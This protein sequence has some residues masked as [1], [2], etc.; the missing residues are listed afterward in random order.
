MAT[1]AEAGLYDR[2]AAIC[3]A[4]N[5]ARA[6]EDRDYMTRDIFYDGAPAA[7]I[8]S[9]R[10]KEEIVAIV[11]EAAAAGLA[12]F[13][14][15]GGMSYT[16]G[17]VPSVE[18]SVLIDLSALDQIITI[19]EANMFVTVQP[20]VTWKQLYEALRE[21]G[22]R[23]PAFGT[24]S[25]AK[26]TVGGGLSQGS[27]F[28]GSTQYGT[29]ADH[30]LGLEV[31]LA[32]GSLVRTGQAA[33]TGSK[34][35]FRWH[36]PD[37]TGPLLGDCGALGIKVE[38]TFRLIRWPEH[39]IT[40]SFGF[41]DFESVWQ[42]QNA[43]ARAGCT[44]DCFSFDAVLQSQL[45]E[46]N[47]LV[48]NVDA[49]RHVV[50]AGGSLF[51][52]LKNAAKIVAGGKGF[53]NESAYSMHVVVEHALKPA[54][55]AAAEEVRLIAT[56]Q[57]GKPIPNS[58][59]Q[60]MRSTPFGSMDQVLGPSGERWVPVH[61][62]IALSDGMEGMKRLLEL[63]ASY[64]PRMIEHGILTGILSNPVGA[65]AMIIEVL[66]YWPDSP[67]ELHEKI[68]S[69]RKLAQARSFASNPAARALVQE[70]RTAILAMFAEVGTAPFGIGKVAPYKQNRD[71]AS[72][73]VLE[74]IKT[75]L[76]PERR[77]NPGA[78]GLS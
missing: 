15:G 34:P 11:R 25:G 52:G 49:L 40:L 38:M 44:A 24:M 36:G 66:F 10:N 57:G 70:I 45:M 63:L 3:G 47:S 59:P 28:Y 77:L 31:V 60:V 73:E 26:A 48:Q 29:T 2:F 53:M 6:G 50:S 55:E 14:R 32:D 78:L 62:F 43:I 65:S 16:K 9:P 22:L 12:V 5:V 23:L 58:I 76:D 46:R 4:E 13:P 64:G 8:V 75:A 41:D 68:L 7:F 21:K 54:A 37:L 30:V 35:Y 74:K 56:A 18:Q 61:G 20:G 27:I 71:P 1:L 67:H 72:Y 19:D 69:P 51:K 42:A 17:Y 33:M 39:M